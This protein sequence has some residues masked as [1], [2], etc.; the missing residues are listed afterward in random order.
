MRIIWGLL[1]I[2][3]REAIFNYI[4]A[5]SLRVAIKVDD[6]IE[7]QIDRLTAT[8]EIERL[9]RVAGTYELIIQK[10]PYIAIYERKGDRVRI[11]RVL[12][13][14]QQWPDEQ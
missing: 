10:T 1:A 13:E 3:D 8:P 2:S 6:R 9:G 4:E 14:D 11:L 7:A 12:H 5:D